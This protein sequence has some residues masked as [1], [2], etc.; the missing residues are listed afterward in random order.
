MTWYKTGTVQVTLN[1]NAVVGTGT[2]FI[3]N[4]RVG[5]A[6]SGPDGNWYEV[7]NVVSNTSLGIYP[8][9]R[10]ASVASGG[11]YVIAPMEGYVKDSADAL[12]AATQVIGQVGTDVSAQVTL[13]TNAA[14]SATNSATNAA[15]SA[16]DANSSK[17]AAKSSEDAAKTSETNASTSRTNAATSATNAGNSAT[18]AANSATQAANSAASVANKANSGANSDI[19]S[20]SGLTTPL[21]VSQGGT[22]RN[23][24]TILYVGDFGVG[25]ALGVRLPSDDANIALANGNYWTPL[26]WTGS[27]YA[28]SDSRNQ[29][30][31]EHQNQ[32]VTTYAVQ[33]WRGILTAYGTFV[34]YKVAGAWQAWVSSGSATTW[35]SITGT[36]SS[37]TDLQAALDAKMDTSLAGFAY[38]YPNGGTVSAPANIAVNQRYT[39]TNPFP[40]LPVICVVEVLYSGQWGDPGWATYVS[41]NNYG[42]RAGQLINSTNG[43]DVIIVKTGTTGVLITGEAGSPHATGPAAG[44]ALPGRVKVWR[45]KG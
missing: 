43:T 34:R 39:V 38:A 28:G 21:S 44:T 19:T 2:A 26:A 29:G 45:L 11:V 23:T 16:T 12:R 13:A 17:V 30:Y 37:Q 41:N 27:P 35:G 8:N 6:F 20:L 22:G 1:S 42:A 40:G 10:G 24:G 4:A 18:A 7:I 3:A 5:D 9:Y 31:L 33:I 36:L 25:G 14:T 15:S 32:G